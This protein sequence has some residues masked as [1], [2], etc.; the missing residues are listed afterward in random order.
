[1]IQVV[2]EY[3]VIDLSI[4][5]LQS[6]HLF[7]ARK[8][9]ERDLSHQGTLRQP[10]DRPLDIHAAGS[11]LSYRP[12]RRPQDELII[13]SLLL[14]EID[15]PYYNVVDFWRS[16]EGTCLTTG[17]SIS[18]ATRLKKKGLSWAPRSPYALPSHGKKSE[19]FY[20][21]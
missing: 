20:R 2:H 10:Y 21:A 6:P 14:K 19:P 7:P 16:R 8:D 3:G 13:W 11:L 18:S 4:L 15:E 5:S 1:M 17:F 12:A 9:T